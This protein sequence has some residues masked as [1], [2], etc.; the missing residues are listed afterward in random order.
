VLDAAN[1]DSTRVLQVRQNHNLNEPLENKIP[2]LTQGFFV[3][4][5]NMLEI[6]RTFVFDPYST[7][8]LLSRGY[9]NP[10]FIQRLHILNKGFLLML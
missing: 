3:A 10:L 8:W 1:I 7:F 2:S 4:E 9:E 6:S 5:Y